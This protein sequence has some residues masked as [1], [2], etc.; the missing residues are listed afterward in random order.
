MQMKAYATLMK[1]IS[2]DVV[3]NCSGMGVLNI[4]L[5]NINLDNDFEGDDPDTIIL[6]R[7]LASHIKFEKRKELK[8]ELSEELM[9]VAWQ[10]NR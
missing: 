3:F 9:P 4:E 6:I 5:N 10:S 7:L 8:K 2:R 1:V